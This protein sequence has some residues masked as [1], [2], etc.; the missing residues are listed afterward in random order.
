MKQ[1][2]RLL[3]LVVLF[4]TVVW[5]Q[6]PQRDSNGNYY[7]VRIDSLQYCAPESLAVVQTD[8]ANKSD[9]KWTAQTS[10]YYKLHNGGVID[11]IEIVGEV[12]V[13]PKLIEFTGPGTPSTTSN[14]PPSA[15][16]YN[17]ILRDTAAG[18]TEA[19][20]YVFVRPSAAGDT[21]ALFQA[22]YLSLQRGD[23]I[24]MRG[25]VDEFPSP[26]TCSYTEFVPIDTGNFVITNNGLLTTPL[27]IIGHKTPQSPI[28]LPDASSF[29]TGAYGSGT[30]NFV[31]GE[32]Y[33]DSY[34]QLTNLRVSSIINST[35]GTF[36]M[37]DQSGNEI[38][39]LDVSPWFTQRA[40]RFANAT[41]QTPMVG[42]TIDTIRGYIACNS[43]TEAARG[44]RICPVFPTDLKLGK[45]PPAINTHRRTPIIVTP[46]DA[47]VISVKSYQQ[48]GS[49]PV[50]ADTLYYSVGKT[51]ANYGAW[52]KIAM[53]GPNPA[54]SAWTAA[55]PAQSDSATVKYFITCSDSVGNKTIL[56]S[57]G[58][59][60]SAIDTTSGFF[61][62]KSSAKAPIIY[63]VQY[64]PYSNGVSPL[65]GASV[66]VSGVVIADTSDI[67]ITNTAGVTPWYIRNGV[68]AWSSIWVSST[69]AAMKA[70]KDGDSITVTGTVV[71]WLDGTTGQVGRV[72]RLS[73]AT[74]GSTLSTGGNANL[75]SITST[76]ANFNYSFNAEYYESCLYHAN[77]IAVS[78]TN[79]TYSD[80]SEFAI[81]DQGGTYLVLVRGSDGNSK[82][83]TNPGDTLYHKTILHKGDKFSYIQGL[84]YYSWGNWKI[85][86]RGNSDYGIYTPKYS[87][88][89]VND[90]QENIPSKFGLSQNY[91]NPYNPTTMIEFDLAM[92]GNV[93][94]R[95]YNI[96]G[97]EVMTLANG[98]Y[99]AGHYSVLFDGSRLSSGMYFY[100]LQSS[101][102]SA[103]RKMMLL[104]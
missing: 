11:T 84:I 40:W 66:T 58:G 31:S 16:G 37:Q 21:V 39:M 54:D 89:G 97:Q 59:G 72:T 95:V 57:A 86:P 81:T 15:G 104:K 53:T 79:P 46:T 9:I 49:N 99:N 73:N 56:A 74:Y 98:Y 45:T 5:A 33:E 10:K 85:I 12:V 78:D 96:L 17:I 7:T 20:R 77:N 22:G 44:Y 14:I 24:R 18:G 80:P 60:A 34:V 4:A 8:G 1:L 103:V 6:R 82:Y 36:S 75:P 102:E 26:N 100:K 35:N 91:P 30:V 32:Q 25:Y 92:K 61:I 19:W 38:G 71:E 68:G 88:T 62:Y 70:V 65:L 101:S 94:L 42:Q 43:G 3:L 13:P 64:T 27:A 48:F 28:N 41:Y 52:N 2:L 83:S 47:P 51:W 87:P 67:K 69:D 63:D 76:I 90:C 50:K 29:M 93:S 23:I 55:I